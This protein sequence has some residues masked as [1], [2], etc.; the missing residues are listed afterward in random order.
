M[1]REKNALADEARCKKAGV[2]ESGGAR[3]SIPEAGLT[4]T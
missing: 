1:R 2:E 3:A 4:I